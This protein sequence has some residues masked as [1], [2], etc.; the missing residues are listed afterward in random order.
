MAYSSV[1]SSSRRFITLPAGLLICHSAKAWAFPPTIATVGRLAN[2]KAKITAGWSSLQFDPYAAQRLPARRQHHRR[3]L[4]D[5]P[6]DRPVNADSVGS[7]RVRTHP[8]HRASPPWWLANDEP[9]F[10]IGFGEEICP[11]MVLSA[12]EQMMRRS[13]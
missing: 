7:E 11:Q 5:R 4:I 12:T 2:R 6:C 8:H 9:S 1:R 13:A 10:Q 3:T